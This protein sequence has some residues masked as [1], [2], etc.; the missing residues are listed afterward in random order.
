MSEEV[1]GIVNEHENKIG[2]HKEEVYNDCNIEFGSK[3][4]ENLKKFNGITYWK[5][6]HFLNI[7]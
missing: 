2:S 3:G 6:K 1:S 5:A 7:A 4:E